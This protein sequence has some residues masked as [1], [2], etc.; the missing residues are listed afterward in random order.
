MK[1]R[2][3][4]ILIAILCISLPALAQT[5]ADKYWILE[6][7]SAFPVTSSYTS[8]N[9]STYPS[10]IIIA[11]KQANVEASS[12]CAAA[13]VPGGNQMRIRGLFYD[14]CMEF[15]VPNASI[16]KIYVSG[17][18]DMLDRSVNIYRN[19]ELVQT[20]GEID[21]TI[22]CKFVDKVNFDGK[23]TYKITAGNVEDANPVVVYY[24]EVVKYGV[25]D[26]E[27]VANAGTFWIKED[28]SQFAVED[29]YNS[30][31][32]YQSYPNDVEINATQANI[33]ENDDCARANSG[34]GNQ[35]RIRGLSSNGAIQFSVPNA[36]VAR[37]YVSGKSSTEDRSVKIFRNDQLVKTYENLDQNVC[38]VFEDSVFSQETVN[39]KITAGE[40]NS[41]SPIAV[42]N[43]E[44]EKYYTPSG[45]GEDFSAY[46]IYEDFNSSQLETG[47]S[48]N[49]YETF[50]KGILVHSQFANIEWGEGCTENSS[51]VR[52]SN[53]EG[54]EGS[55]EFTVPDYGGIEIGVTGKS[56][57]MDRVV[58]VYI[59]NELVQ[60]IANLDRNN[61][62][63]FSIAEPAEKETK[64]KITGGNNNGPVA[65]SYIHIPTYKSVVSIENPNLSPVSI[66][67]NPVSD[68]I[69]FDYNNGNPVQKVWI[70]DLS[71]KQI[72]SA[73]NISRMDVSFLQ[74][75]IYLL[76]IQT[77][78][79]IYT[80]KL[81]KK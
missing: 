48:S 37:I 15:S 32:A 78:E 11:T 67:P 4:L 35:M 58:L 52:I 59:N 39:Y 68:I 24:V 9:Y 26:P 3:T 25:E 56:T 2:F 5:D 23:L 50:P 20:Y 47:Y 77:N 66:F 17:K 60:T 30:S 12:F 34:Y 63:V 75:G 76:K 51:I 18:S 79:G 64:I 44:V 72:L 61:C 73:T 33:E 28:F 1:R 42:Y 14:G 22:C 55:I 7:F 6:D 81:I 31:K 19:G 27:K 16:V 71:G 57:S 21:R 70:I 74:K 29:G 49:Q 10:D 62:E 36:G 45:D 53:R 80:H 38:R 8:D 65:V 43:I 69:F 54:E 13:N 40:E 41:T 46:W